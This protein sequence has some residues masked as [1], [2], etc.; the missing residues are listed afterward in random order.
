MS[1]LGLGQFALKDV[2]VHVRGDHGQVVIEDPI[3]A[4]CDAVDPGFAISPQRVQNGYPALRAHTREA[5]EA[6]SGAAVNSPVVAALTHTEIH[7][8]RVLTFL[9]DM[10]RGYY[11]FQ[12]LVRTTTQGTFV[13]RPTRVAAACSPGVFRPVAAGRVAVE[14]RGGESSDRAPRRTQHRHRTCSGGSPAVMVHAGT[15]GRT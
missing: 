11:R 9:G 15:V 1:R 14:A 5:I 10:S 7:P 8:A 2:A 4:S 3:A 6:A 12:T 13:L